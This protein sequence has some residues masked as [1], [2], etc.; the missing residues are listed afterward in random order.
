MLVVCGVFVV[1]CRPH[2]RFWNCIGA[3]VDAR[4]SVSH[5]SGPPP[6]GGGGG[7]TCQRSLASSFDTLADSKS[8][9]AGGRTHSKS[10]GHCRALLH[11]PCRMLHG[12]CRMPGLIV[13]SACKHMFAHLPRSGMRSRVFRYEQQQQQTPREVMRSMRHDVQDLAL[14]ADGERSP[15]CVC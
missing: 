6:A 1:Q 2:V 9:E 4:H 7:P 8:N 5:R 14:L 3:D 15:L 12:P 13:G 11:V 10:R